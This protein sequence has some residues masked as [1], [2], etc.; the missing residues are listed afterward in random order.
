MIAAWY[1]TFV[2]G[3]HGALD[4]VG[5]LPSHL[6]PAFPDNG[7]GQPLRFLAQ[8]YCDGTRLHLPGVLCLQIYQDEPD[9]DPIPVPVFVPVGALPNSNESGRPAPDVILHDIEWEYREDPDE[10]SDDRVDIAKSKLGGVCYFSHALD[11]GERLLLFLEEYPPEFNFGG[12]ELML[13]VDSV[14]KVRVA[15]A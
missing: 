2:P 4:R 14:G 15:C 6:P 9:G 13:A 10:P 8:F 1:M 7:A 3:H 11:Q 5:G 12:D